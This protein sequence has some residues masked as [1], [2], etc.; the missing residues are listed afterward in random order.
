MAILF[1]ACLVIASVVKQFTTFLLRD[2]PRDVEVVQ[3]AVASL[4]EVQ[5]KLGLPQVLL[6]LAFTN[7]CNGIRYS[8]S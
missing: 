6:L 7:F 3:A 4:N 1:C 5:L 8:N 2:S